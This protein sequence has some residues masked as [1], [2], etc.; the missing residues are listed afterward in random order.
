MLYTRIARSLSEASHFGSRI[1]E[2][3]IYGDTILMLFLGG[4]WGI[5]GLGIGVI[6]GRKGKGRGGEGCI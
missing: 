1:Q 4:F 5:L 2:F 6:G 3:G